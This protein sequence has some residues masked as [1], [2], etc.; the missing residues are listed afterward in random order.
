MMAAAQDM[1]DGKFG[2][3]RDMAPVADLR[4]AFSRES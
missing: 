1:R 3:I 4:R 2:F